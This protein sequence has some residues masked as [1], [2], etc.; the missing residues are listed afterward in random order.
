MKSKNRKI[1]SARTAKKND[2]FEKPITDE[3]LKTTGKKINTSKGSFR[4]LDDKK[5]KSGK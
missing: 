2:Q 5:G 4:S 1:E 3:D